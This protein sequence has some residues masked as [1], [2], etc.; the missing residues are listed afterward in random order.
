FDRVDGAANLAR[1]LD[2]IESSGVA[3]DAI[4]FTGDLADL[5]EP[6]VYRDLRSL[7]EPL[8]ERIGARVLW[9][10]GN[11]DERAA[12]RRGLLGED[13]SAGDLLRPF[14]RVDELDGLRVITLDTTVPGHHHGEVSDEQ[15]D[16]LAAE[17]ATPAPLG[18]ILA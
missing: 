6:G 12:F 18:T 2:V 15:L 16:W 11:H 10:M 9:V 14:D 7:V 4:V 3:P 17:L 1:A 5:G 8:A 13:G